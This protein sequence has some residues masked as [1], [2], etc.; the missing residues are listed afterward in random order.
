MCCDMSSVTR[1]GCSSSTVSQSRVFLRWGTCMLGTA[2]DPKTLFLKICFP[3]SD[4]PALYRA[5]LPDI[6]Q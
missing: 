6:S 3:L 1:S 2:A 4:L 5:K